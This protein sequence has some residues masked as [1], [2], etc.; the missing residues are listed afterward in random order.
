MALYCFHEFHIGSAGGGVGKIPM[1]A[2]IN[3]K[4]HSANSI[5]RI[6]LK[7]VF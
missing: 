1:E 6:I 5:L 2:I 7:V 4:S 3:I